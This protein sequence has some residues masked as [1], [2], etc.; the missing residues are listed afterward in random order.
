MEEKTMDEGK[1]LIVIGKDG[2]DRVR[3][4]AP[5]EKKEKQILE[6]YSKIQGAVSRFRKNTDKILRAA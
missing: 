6:V 5:T 1:I 2:V 4:I 3:F